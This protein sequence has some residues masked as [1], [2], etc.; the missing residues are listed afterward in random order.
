[1]GLKGTNRWDPT[2]EKCL[3]DLVKKYEI[4]PNWNEISKLFEERTKIKRSPNALKERWF[5]PMALRRNP[6]PYLSRT[7]K[8][9]DNKIEE[10]DAEQTEPEQSEYSDDDDDDGYHAKKKKGKMKI[11]TNSEDQM[12]LKIIKKM[13]KKRKYK[14]V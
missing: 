7:A 10:E 4:D 6:R 12:A 2:Q 14:K 8:D 3:K 11:W 13:E 5:G 9:N 1:M